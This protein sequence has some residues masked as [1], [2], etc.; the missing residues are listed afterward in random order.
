MLRDEHQGSARRLTFTAAAWT[1]SSLTTSVKL[2]K[3]SVNGGERPVRYWMHGNMLT[4]NGRKMAKSEGNGFTPEELITGNHKLLDKGYTPMTVRFF[5]LMGHYAS[6]LDFSNEAL[7]AAEKGLSK[8]EK[9]M[10]TL[11]GLEPTSGEAGYDVQ[12][13]AEKCHA[14]MNDDFNTPTLIATLFDGV[15]AI[16][17]AAAGRVTLSA[18]DIASLKGTFD[19]FCEACWACKPKAQLEVQKEKQGP[20]S[21]MWTCAPRLKRTKT[22]APQTKF[23]MSLAITALQFKTVHGSTWTRG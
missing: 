9:A 12:A 5:M 15:K 2:P 1:S 14:A 10:E 6:T 20:C 22:G 8:L 18:E 11:A 16:N 7:Q 19:A 13:Y 23:V 3:T 4:V 17:G 21:T